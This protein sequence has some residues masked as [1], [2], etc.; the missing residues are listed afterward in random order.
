MWPQK[1][2]EY[3]QHMLT[4][5]EVVVKIRIRYRANVVIGKRFQA[6]QTSKI[7]NINSVINWEERNVYLD[8]ICVE[9]V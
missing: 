6:I 7:Y 1:G 5:G 9:E 8:C 3:V 2:A 4:K